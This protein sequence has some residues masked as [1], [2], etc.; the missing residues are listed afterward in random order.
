[1]REEAMEEKSWTL[2]D[3]IREYIPNVT[4]MEAEFIVWE[5]TGYPSFWDIPTDG[6]T[7]E[8]C[9]RKQVQEYAKGREAVKEES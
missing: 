9:F 6:Q 5:K 1:M 8:E 7:P 2:I 3:V 4:E